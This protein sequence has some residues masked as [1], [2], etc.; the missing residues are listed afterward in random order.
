M[1]LAWETPNPGLGPSL[2]YDAEGTWVA[3]I[4]KVR[5]VWHG[6]YDPAGLE[7]PPRAPFGQNDPGT[8]IGTWN[9]A[10][11]TMQALDQHHDR[12]P[13]SHR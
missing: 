10:E 8:L 4:R 6:W 2:G 3:R 12:H 11:E 13:G 7:R 9:T 1:A 5:N